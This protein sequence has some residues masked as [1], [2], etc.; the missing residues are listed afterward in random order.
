MVSALDQPPPYAPGYG[1]APSP[2]FGRDDVLHQIGEVVRSADFGVGGG[3][4]RLIG[5]RGTGKTSVLAEVE[6]RITDRDELATLTGRKRPKPWVVLRSEAGE[7]LAADLVAK[8]ARIGPT[9]D[10]RRSWDVTLGGALPGGMASVQARRQRAPAATTLTSALEELADASANDGRSLMVIIDELHEISRNDL[11]SITGITNQLSGSRHPVVML[12][13]ELPERLDLD[14]IT[15]FRDRAQRLAIGGLEPTAAYAALVAPAE[16][17]GVDWDPKAA[18]GVVKAS[19]GYPYALQV[20]AAA[21][22][23][24]ARAREDDHIS[25]D[26]AREG[27]IRGREQLNQLYAERWARLPERP[28]RYLTALAHIETGD[29]PVRTREVAAALGDPPQSW[30]QVLARLRDDHGAVLTARG[31]VHFALPGWA[32]WIRDQERAKPLL[33]ADDVAR[34]RAGR[35]GRPDR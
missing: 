10:R 16:A 28:R 27:L 24:A 21:C 33:G 9:I 29:I 22:W 3:A 19:G 20:N 5:L 23:N 15:Y 30:S 14:H 17:R 7:D 8:I 1:H 32:R 2:M 26:A 35:E 25:I 34:L 12:T 18:T 6:R 31:Q 4:V 11:R 13:A